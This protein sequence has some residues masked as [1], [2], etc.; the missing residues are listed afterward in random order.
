MKT[1][2]IAAEETPDAWAAHFRSELPAHQVLVAPVAAGTPATYL[3]VG[4]PPPGLIASLTG[5]ELVLSLN[6][7]IEPLLEPG[8]VPPMIPIVR[9]VD[10]GLTEG[11]VEWVLAQVLAW[12]RNLFAYADS[13]KSAFWAPRPEVLAKERTVTV[14]GAGALGR[15]VAEAL[16]GLGFR[17][18]IWSRAPRVVWRVLAFSGLEALPQAF[19][20]ADREPPGRRGVRQAREGGRR[21]QRRARRPHCGRGPDVGAGHRPAERRG[22]GC[23]P[24]GAVGVR[25]PVLDSSRRTG[26]AARRRADPPTHRRRSDGR[27]RAPLGER[28][29]SG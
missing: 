12:H 10:D 20:R 8:E 26:V 5:L 29:A 17:T 11:M 6:A 19:D 28:R 9:M 22:V 23:L 13:Q 1:L 21:H 4:K 27:E 25:P 3:V 2:L 7:G 16:A 24:A 18:R 14:L 15:P